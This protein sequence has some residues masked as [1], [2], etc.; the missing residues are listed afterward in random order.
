MNYFPTE[1]YLVFFFLFQIS[2]QGT[3]FI[4]NLFAF[5]YFQ[6]IEF[7]ILTCCEIDGFNNRLDTSKEQ[8]SELKKSSEEIIQNAVQRDK[9]MKNVKKWLKHMKDTVIYV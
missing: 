8:L 9:R 2:L 7:Y 4:Q 6:G 5:E 3:S 1:R